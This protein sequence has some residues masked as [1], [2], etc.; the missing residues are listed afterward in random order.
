LKKPAFWLWLILSAWPPELAARAFGWE[1]VD[2]AYIGVMLVWWPVDVLARLA[3][4]KILLEGTDGPVGHHYAEPWAALRATLTAEVML[5]LKVCTPA[6]LGLI[7]AIALASHPP[8]SSGG[9]ALLLLLAALGVLP[10]LRYYFAR[11]LAPIAILRH[12]LRAHDALDASAQQTRGR[13]GLFLRLLLPWTAVSW[14]LD[15]VGMAAPDAVALALMPLSLAAGLL[16][17][18]KA[19]QGLR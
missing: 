19:D 13:F 16:A 7:P 4:L 15:L 5:S 11:V 12:D 10:A 8:E 17:L 1:I 3:A 18:R 2:P 6:L 9:R 14:A